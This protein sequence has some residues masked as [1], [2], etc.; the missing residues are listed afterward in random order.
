LKRLLKSRPVDQAL[1]GAAL[2]VTDRRWAAPLSAAA[3][4]FGIFAGVAIGPG[5]AGSLATSAQQVIEIPSSG[6]GDGQSG[7]GG[8]GIASTEPSLPSL[9][10]EA[11]G[12]FEES[13]P[14][15]LPLAPEPVEPLPAPTNE[16][17]AKPTPASEESDGEAEKPEGQS[18]EGTVVHA[19]PAAGSYAIAIKGGELLSVHAPELPE[20]GTKLSASL[21]PLANSTY[22]EADELEA[23]KKKA[24]E[25]LFD[26]TV[27]FADP[28]PAAPVY[29][30]SSRGSSLLVHVEPDPSGTAPALPAIGS[31]VTVIAKIEPPAEPKASSTLVQS[32]LKVESVPP[33]TY[34]ELAG[35]VKEI[36]PETG[37][38]LF[39]ADWAGESESTITLAVAPEI[40][41]KKLKAGDSYLATAEI[42]DDGSLTLK[43]IASDEHSKG[44][45]DASSAQGDLER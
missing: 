20:P 38:L 30:V 9:G 19:N 42:A 40:D 6:G 36:L 26:G 10:H 41:A 17:A 23:E 3:L 14:S 15:T 1:R 16:P 43:G 25:V 32:K 24:T 22:A 5:T 2:V 12:G 4:G 8:G 34:L 33:S 11:S 27:T 44:A 18:F 21:R 29:A 31:L 45:D 28:N 7:G 35:I 37:Q 39:S 13:L